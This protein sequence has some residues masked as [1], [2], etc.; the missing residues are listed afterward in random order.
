MVMMFEGTYVSYLFVTELLETRFTTIARVVQ[1]WSSF[2]INAPISVI[3]VNY[4][5]RKTLLIIIHFIV[6]IINNIIIIII[7]T[8]E[9]G[10]NIII[11]RLS[12]FIVRQRS[13][14][15]SL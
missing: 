7:P 2:F 8:S 12:S 6:I 10:Y 5:D 15:D 11:Y 1:N 4:D 3:T 13:C 14:I 9:A